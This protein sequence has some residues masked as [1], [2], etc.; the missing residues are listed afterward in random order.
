MTPGGGFL[1]HHPPLL[2]AFGSTKVLVFFCLGNSS[3][4]LCS[5]TWQCKM[6]HES[7][8]IF[9][10]EDTIM[11]HWLNIVVDEYQ[12]NMKKW[13]NIRWLVGDDTTG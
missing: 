10:L 8:C 11:W 2:V 6:T 12:K 5:G 3:G 4:S 13:N 9:T 7:H 1:V